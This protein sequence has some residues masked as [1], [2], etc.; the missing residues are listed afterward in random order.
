MMKVGWLLAW[1]AL[2]NAGLGS[3]LHIA[4]VVIDEDNLARPDVRVGLFKADADEQMDIPQ[5]DPPD[6]DQIIEGRGWWQQTNRDGEFLF[7]GLHRG[8]YLLSVME[9][10][11]AGGMEYAMIDIE[12]AEGSVSNVCL[13][14]GVISR[15]V[16]RGILRSSRTGEPIQ[17]EVSLMPDD[18]EVT[19][20]SVTW[21]LETIQPVQTGPEGGFVK[22]GMPAGS[23]SIRLS[24]LDEVVYG[25]TEIGLNIRVDDAGAVT[26][27]PLYRAYLNEAGLDLR[28]EG[29]DEPGDERGL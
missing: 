4:G 16:L 2:G 26:I 27:G 13:L 3:D 28:F 18:L 11:P 7:T 6:W 10:P 19:P 5:G 29:A 14:P 17:A 12:L 21:M 15:H 8:N 20:G 23:Y 24:G 22:A 1:L 25:R 9:D